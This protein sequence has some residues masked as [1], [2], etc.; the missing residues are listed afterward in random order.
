MI[1]LV[2][3]ATGR[4]G[5][6]FV[7]RLLSE[8]EPARVLVRDPGAAEALRRRGAEL[9]VGQLADG[10]ALRRAL[11]GV[12]RVV[13]LAASFR[14]VPEQEV[15]AVNLDGTMR[16]AHAAVEA[17]VRRFVFAS[18]N[19][20]YGPGRG[21]PAREQDEPAPAMVY[22]RA[23]V[24]AERALRELAQH[25]RLGLRVVRLAFVYGEGDPH[26]RESLP[27]TRE[28]PAH[29]RLH[30]VHHADAGQGLLRALRA[31]GVD[32]AAFNI[33]DD[34]PVTALELH[35]LNGEEISAEAA[36]RPLDDPWD[37]IVDVAAA[38]QR[39]GYRPIFPTVYAARDAGAL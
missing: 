17:G 1:T 21:R 29:R 19:L 14:G 15:E 8:G 20:V 25:E 32:G 39:L 13:H 16:L 22:P 30:L 6:R 34:A 5:S 2:T 3:G 26:L 18:T 37:G 33:A 9:A 4:V 27:W 10:D 28:W 7:P 23:K 31:D 11:D 38:R 12:E 35:A 36:S 24:A